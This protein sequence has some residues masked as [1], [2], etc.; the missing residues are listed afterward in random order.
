M[1]NKLHKEQQRFNDKVVLGLLGLGILGTLYGAVAAL[2]APAA[3]LLTAAVYF[4]VALFL[5]GWMY[6][7]INL[8]LQVNVT[9]KSIK[10]DLVTPV[11]RV[12]R[13]INW[14]NVVSCNL[15]KTPEIA[16]WH[17]ANLS[18]GNGDRVSLAGQNGLELTTK[19]GR[20]HFI[21]CKEVEALRKALA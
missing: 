1:A 2:L 6:W 14:K 12:S 17:G 3:A 4:G 16:Q 15:V 8:R 5:A 19:D 10:Y 11:N 9:D 21:G 18:Y 7:L 20:K 13:K